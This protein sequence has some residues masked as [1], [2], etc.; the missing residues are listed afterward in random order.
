MAAYGASKAFVLHW[1]LALNEELRGSGVRTLAVCPGPTATDF[2]RRAGLQEGSAADA[3]SMPCD[4]V[5]TK[6]LQALAAG[7]SQVVTGWKNKL[8]AIAGSLA[9]KPLAARAAAVMLAR[10]RLKQVSR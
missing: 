7:R 6:A 9:P 5:V 3:M 4:A 10:F 1:S 8:V 2:F